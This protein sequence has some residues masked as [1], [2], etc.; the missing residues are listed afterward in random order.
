MK[1]LLAV[2]A[3]CLVVGC[4]AVGGLLVPPADPRPAANA[5]DMLYFTAKDTDP[6]DAQRAAAA[7]ARAREIALAVA[8]SEAEL[9][10]RLRELAD[11][12]AQSGIPLGN[13]VATAVGG[14]ALLVTVGKSAWRAWKGQPGPEALADA[15][16][17]AKPAPGTPPTA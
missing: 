13:T 7:N 10:A 4:S 11:R 16:A 8:K 3:L 2:A 9:D 12:A 14:L 6:A 1:R 15:V 17:A 5:S